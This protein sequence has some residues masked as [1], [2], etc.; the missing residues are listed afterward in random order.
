MI[1]DNQKSGLSTN[2]L[3]TFLTMDEK[4][5]SAIMSAVVHPETDQ[6]I[7]ASGIATTSTLE[8]GKSIVKL[9]FPKA[10]DPFAVKIKNR[11]EEL[12]RERFGS[13]AD[14]CTVIITDARP[15]HPKPQMR[16]AA[17]DI[18]KIISIAS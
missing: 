4:Q 11:I 9:A 8:N 3:N 7:V 12:L 18:D 6:N 17:E 13:R 16:S 5:I 15:Q 1:L 2:L 14:D 10:R